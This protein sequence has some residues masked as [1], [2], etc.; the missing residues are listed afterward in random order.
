[1]LLL[2]TVVLAT[3]RAR[4]VPDPQLR[5]AAGAV[6][7]AEVAMLV[8]S[9]TVATFSW[10]QLSALFWLIVGAGLVINRVGGTEEAH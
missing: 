5:A 1:M 4:D 9:F 6:L 7:A 3:W 10:A 8:T 2:G